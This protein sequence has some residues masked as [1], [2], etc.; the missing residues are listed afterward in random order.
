MGDR[1]G[2][3]SVEGEVVMNE[4]EDICISVD[5]VIACQDLGTSHL[6]VYVG[7]E[8]TRQRVLGGGEEK[9]YQWFTATHHM[10]GQRTA[11][12]VRTIQRCLSKL[13]EVGLVEI[14]RETIREWNGTLKSEPNVYRLR[15]KW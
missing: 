11:C 1:R 3:S 9:R 14:E 7:L 13:E 12:G 5:A 6:D 8:R 2:A 4:V 10:I 15:G